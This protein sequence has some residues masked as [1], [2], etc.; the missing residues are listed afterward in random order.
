MKIAY[1]IPFLLIVQVLHA[2]IYD[3]LI[4][5]GVSRVYRKH[6]PPIHTSGLPIVFV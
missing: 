3:T 4:V 1:Y 6:I 5:R 2:Q